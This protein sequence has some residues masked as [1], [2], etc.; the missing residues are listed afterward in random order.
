MAALKSLSFAALPKSTNDPV[1]ARRTKVVDRLE[2]QKRLLVTRT[3]SG[4][5]S[6]G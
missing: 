5:F 1:S 2:E 4:P 3:T 6:D